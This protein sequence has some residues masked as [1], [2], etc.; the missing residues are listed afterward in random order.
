M[1]P[2]RLKASIC[3]LIFGFILGF[4]MAVFFVPVDASSESSKHLPVPAK[5]LNIQA[6]AIEKDYQT[7]VAVLKDQNSKLQT[8]LTSTKAL[9]K[10]VKAS[11]KQR[12]Y[13]VKKII[14][15]NSHQKKDQSL[16][17][18]SIP[19]FNN[20][21]CDSLKMEV[22]NYINENNRKDSLYEIQMVTMD[23][24]VRVKD[25]IIQVNEGFHNS[26]REIF[27]KAINEQKILEVENRL[28]KKKEKRRKLGSKILG[29]GLLVL[30][31][32]L[33]KNF[34]HH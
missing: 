3:I 21:I 15:V 14:A 25:S 20:C 19:L 31:G 9:L 30:S 5:E 33:I 28:L 13:K 1:F 29:G 24:V 2:L 10:Q 4:C 32:T 7:R 8:D 34:I 16:E 18:Y 6:I 27:N 12:E 26:F 23:S 22:T 17:N 11:S